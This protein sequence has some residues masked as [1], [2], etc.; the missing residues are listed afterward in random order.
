MILNVVAL[1]L[2]AIFFKY[3]PPVNDSVSSP[4]YPWQ[5]IVEKVI[6]CSLIGS[7]F[8][9]VEKLLLQMIAVNFHRRAYSERLVESQFASYVLERLYAAKKNRSML[10][11][12]SKQQAAARSSSVQLFGRVRQ[13]STVTSPV[14]KT[15]STSKPISSMEVLEM[16]RL[17]TA[18][19]S[20]S[21]EASQESF[22]DGVEDNQPGESSAV[23]SP[24][25]ETSPESPTSPRETTIVPESLDA[26]PRQKKKSTF[27]SKTKRALRQPF[28]F[29]AALS[30]ASGV[31]A[32]MQQTKGVLETVT[33]ATLHT[34]ITGATS[35]T[36]THFC[37]DI[38]LLTRG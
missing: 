11:L 1:T 19:G 20:K 31:S 32:L 6:L 27:K 5:G 35:E 21:I 26:T 13:R 36:G 9:L 24:A 10:Q 25:S 18:G 34:I 8:L 28:N 15:S 38:I 37:V 3:T 33:H 17:P 22:R 16:M 23:H 4:G 14:G 12:V 29:M 2:W 30:N 7:V